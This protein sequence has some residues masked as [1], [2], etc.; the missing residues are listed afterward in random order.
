M[1]AGHPDRH[2]E[3]HRLQRMRDRLQEGQSSGARRSPPL[4]P[5]R[6]PVGQ[7]LDLDR[8]R[9]EPCLRAQAVPPLPGAGLRVGL[10][11]GRTCTKPRPGRGLRQRE[12]HGLP[13]L[14]DGLPL[15]HPPLRLGPDGALRAQVHPLLR[16]DS[17]RAASRP[18]P[19]R[20]PRKRPSSATATRCSRKRTAA[21]ARTPA[22]YI[23]K[24]WG[25]HEV[26]GTS[27]LY[28]SN[29][30]LSFLTQRPA[31]SDDTPLPE[32]TAAAMNAV[33]FAFTGV[34]AAMAGMNWIIDRRMKRR[35]GRRR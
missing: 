8:R 12:V 29:V 23:D 32:K 21:S 1:K 18:A 28:I 11:G 10:P 24:V 14:H 4:G 7:Q 31:R 35:D 22:R 30:D 19:R 3:M 13:L 2:D 6:R 25:E 33:P 5:R 20:A 27:V 17:R 9:P 26:G 15:R 16:P 34:V